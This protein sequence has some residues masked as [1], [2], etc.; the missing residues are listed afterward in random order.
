MILHLSPSENILSSKISMDL[1]SVNEDQ[2][3]P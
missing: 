2:T 1:A 3:D